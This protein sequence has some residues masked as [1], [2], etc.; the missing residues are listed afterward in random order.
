[1][2]DETPL[3]HPIADGNETIDDGKPVL[4]LAD[5]VIAFI[6]RSVESG[7]EALLGLANAILNDSGD[8]PIGRIIS[9]HP[10]KQQI[11]A[12]DRWFRLDVLAETV[13][14]EIVLL[15]V[16]IDKQRFFNTRSMI[17]AMDSLQ[18]K[19]EKGDLWDAIAL[20]MPRVISINILNFDL[21]K[22]GISF[23]QIIEPVY[24]E[25]PREVAEYH[26][27]THNIELPKFR[28]IEPDWS[29]PLHLWLTAVCRAYDQNK[30][31]R[32]VVDMEPELKSFEAAD[33]AFAQFVNSYALANADRETRRQ[34]NRWR[35]DQGFR[36]MELKAE[37]FEGK[38]EGIIEG[39]AEGKAEGII[40][41]KAEGI[42]EGKAEGII[43]GKAEGIIEGKAE[44]IIVGKA[45]GINSVAINLLKMNMPIEQIIAAT[46]LTR[47]EIAALS[48]K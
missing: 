23:H 29:N 12:G 20:K 15:E 1:M 42:I 44:G 3:V 48:E 41:G 46:S 13:D 45:Q 37:R 30:T 2:N 4:P 35:L 47:E 24:R 11:G 38:A 5:P 31:L 9:I 40:E 10:Q 17:Y 14:N 19:I 6:F 32:E 34:Y 39:K 43:E 8:G 26:H 21:R 18:Q 33:T 16:Q 36:K 25:E 28:R 7:G 27:V 22:N